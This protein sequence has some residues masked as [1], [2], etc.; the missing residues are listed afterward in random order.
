M[1]RVLRF[2]GFASLGILLLSPISAYPQTPPPAAPPPAAATAQAP[3]APPVTAAQIQAP[4]P[5][6]AA[7]AQVPTAPPVV[8]VTGGQPG[9]QA[10]GKVGYGAF[11]IDPSK[12]PPGAVDKSY[13][14]SP[15]DKLV[16][17]VWGQLQLT[18]KLEVTSDLYLEI[19]DVPGRI[20]VSGLSLG[21]VAER[22]RQQLATAYAS[23]INL[24][25]PTASTAF[26][27]LSMAEVRD[28]RFLVLGDVKTPG[29]YALHPSNA[30]ILYA[31]A[32]AGG[33]LESGSL[34]AI[35]IR[36]G[37]ELLTFDFYQV[38]LAGEQN[39]K[40]WQ[41]RNND[42]IFVPAKGAEVTVQG[43]VKRPGTF[44]LRDPKV[45][46]LVA[47]L[48]L[49]GGFKQT[50]DSDRLLVRR[51]EQNQGPHTLDVNMVDLQK[52]GKKF[53]LQDQD[54]VVVSPT[55]TTRFDYVSVRGNGVVKQRDQQ[56]QP[57]MRVSDLINSVGGVKRDA[58]MKRADL[59]R[60]RPD[61][62]KTYRQVDLGKALAGDA[63]QNLVL[64]PLDELTVYAI[65]EIEGGEKF[66]QLS[67]HV[68]SPGK[69][70]LGAGMR[71]YDVLFGRGGFE[72]RDYLRETYLER[73]DLV[74]AVQTGGVVRRELVKFDLGKL[75][76]GEQ[77]LNVELRSDDEVIVYSKDQILGGDRFVTLSGYAKSP[78]SLRYYQGMHV[79]DVLYTAGGY[80]DPDFRRLAFLP[81]G[82]LLRPVNRDGKLEKELMRFN[83]GALLAGDAKENI[84]LQS[85]DEV[86]LYAAKDFEE[87]RYAY[88]DGAVNRPGKYELAL[89][90]TL[91]DLIIRGGGLKEMADSS[92]VEV[93]R[94][95]VS[96][97]A[98]VKVE[99]VQVALTD[100]TFALKS[101]DR[102][103]ARPRA[104]FQ[105]PR[106]VEIRGEV[107]YP[108]RYTLLEGAGRLADLIH[109]AGDLLKIAFVPGVELWRATADQ[110]EDAR[111]TTHEA[112]QPTYRVVIDLER[113]LDNP[114]SDSNIVL[115]SG[116]SL[117]VPL[118]ANT[119]R[120]EG[121]VN[122]PVTITW[123]SG[124]GVGYYLAAAGGPKTSANRDAIT[125]VLPSGKT[126]SKTLW[127]LLGPSV[128]PGSVIRVPPRFSP[129]VPVPVVAPPPPA[130]APVV[131]KEPTPPVVK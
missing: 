29:S 7:Q 81:R 109:A 122:Q 89:N 74:R 26:I 65:S 70:T 106:V 9:A 25:Q 126:S 116:D 103:R 56:I 4:P 87:K 96:G 36:R 124:K 12:L 114:S 6:A 44:E 51:T 129:V 66:V 23:F 62:S 24:E 28:L 17:R 78:G 64:E 117:V 34:R 108:G 98:D 59:V 33:P 5:G 14:L 104:G 2:V 91:E 90:T 18:Y 80:Q 77:G 19:P 76:A 16:L 31:L 112:A 72:D 53:Y 101:N 1:T 57:G 123:R 48:A 83:L 86:V 118:P 54:V 73:A 15:G 50:A 95:A 52:R 42:V 46:D 82:D 61:R 121:E 43:E 13:I 37:Q 130:P 99:T 63:A 119:V 39:F 88:L 11:N 85:G 93:S 10:E 21:E 94:M 127:G 105:E 20:Y 115:H 113:A 84:E 125:V 41:I 102:V 3:T 97:S 58:Y 71:L 8:G 60:T 38:I 100:R 67:G 32:M 131:I 120:V 40:L 111:N 55:D 75:L 45:E 22:V 30:N 68:K 69:V 79:L 110:S 92:E 35:T 107:R 128:Q 47:V 49:A 27:D